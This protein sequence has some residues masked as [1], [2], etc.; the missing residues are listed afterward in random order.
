MNGTGLIPISAIVWKGVMFY[1]IST[2]INKINS[3]DLL[4]YTF[5]EKYQLFERGRKLALVEEFFF[6]MGRGQMWWNIGIK[7]FYWER[8]VEQN[9]Y[10]VLYWTGQY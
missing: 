10:T 9:M 4:L 5:R 1:N 6:T 7:H 8:I 3:E 2:I